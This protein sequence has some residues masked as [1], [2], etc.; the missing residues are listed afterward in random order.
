MLRVTSIVF[1]LPGARAEGLVPRHGA[2]GSA[3]GEGKRSPKGRGASPTAMLRVT[4]IV[5]ELPGARA[6]GLL[7]CKGIVSGGATRLARRVFGARGMS[8]EQ[9]GHCETSTLQILA[10]WQRVGL[11]NDGQINKGRSEPR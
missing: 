10:N 11:L 1:E 6:E 3:G 4:S 8:A 2:L 5:F 9:E 7:C